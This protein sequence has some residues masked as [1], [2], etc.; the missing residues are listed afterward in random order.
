MVNGKKLNVQLGGLHSHISFIYGVYY[1]ANCNEQCQIKRRPSDLN[2]QV[3]PTID[4]PFY[5]KYLQSVCPRILYFSPLYVAHS[6]TPVSCD[7]RIERTS[8]TV[9]EF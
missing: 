4:L 5:N 9:S 2:P 6:Q 3:D 1:T 8:T 7:R